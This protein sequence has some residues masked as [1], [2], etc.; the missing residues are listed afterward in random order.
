MGKKA[1]KCAVALFLV[2]T[3]PVYGDT[4]TPSTGNLSLIF[5]DWTNSADAGRSDAYSAPYTVS[6]DSP[7]ESEAPSL[8]AISTP[9]LNPETTLFY[10]TNDITSSFTPSASSALFPPIITDNASLEMAPF[11]NRGNIPGL[12]VPGASF[13]GG[14]DLGGA[15]S[16]S[17]YQYNLRFVGE[18]QTNISETP[19][20]PEGNTGA[21]MMTVPAPSPNDTIV[22]EPATLALVGFALVGW[23]S[24]K[25][26]HRLIRS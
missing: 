14:Q 7:A 9:P 13:G 25:L 4:V 26:R 2:L 21:E 17:G 11:F 19:E 20:L 16:Y 22:P 8:S 10:S 18:G 23:A 5:N 6:S 3:M 12:P 1:I 24:T 15:G